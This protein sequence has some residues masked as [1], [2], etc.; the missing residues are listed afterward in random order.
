MNSAVDTF[1]RDRLPAAADLPEFVF[2]LPELEA[3]QGPVRLNAAADSIAGV[4]TL[5]AGHP[6]WRIP[7]TG[8]LVGADFWYIANSQLDRLDDAGRLAPPESLEATTILRLRV[9]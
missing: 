1:A 2:D 6:L 5:L 4:D 9:R 7:T 8:T 3:L